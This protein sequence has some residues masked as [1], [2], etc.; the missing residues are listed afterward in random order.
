[1]DLSNAAVYFTADVP[2][3][4]TATLAVLVTVLVLIPN[5][6]GTDGQAESVPRRRAK[7]D[8]AEVPIRGQRSYQ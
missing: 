3:L 8:W 7:I 5:A 2:K 6:V 4:R 1:M